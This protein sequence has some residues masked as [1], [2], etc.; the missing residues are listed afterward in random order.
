MTATFLTASDLQVRLAGRD[1]LQGVSLAL[2]RQG[3]I[4]LVGPNGAGKTTLL[5]ALAGLLPA[6]EMI[7]GTIRLDDVDV[8]TL[9]VRER[10]RRFAYLPQG[11]AVHWPLPVHDVVALGRYP[12]GATDP[13]RLSATDE[14]AVARAMRTA[15]VEQFAARSIM[16][17]SG[18]ERSR[19]A[20]ARVLAVEAPVILADEPIAS[21]DPRHQ[22]DVMRGLHAAAGDG[23]LVIVVTHDLGLAARFADQMLVLSNGRLVAQGTCDT[24]LSDTILAEVFRIEAYRAVHGDA[25]VIVPWTER[26]R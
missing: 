18:G 13:S 17:L 24:A 22:I 5:R 6:K 1:V 16:E 26:L 23:K 3:L 19:V 21:L 20:L 14:A 4:A 25:T 12:H 2:P 8:A 9:S 10:A 11:H 7:R 15:D